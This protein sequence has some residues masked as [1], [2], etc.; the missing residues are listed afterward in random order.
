MTYVIRLGYKRP[1]AAYRFGTQSLGLYEVLS[2]GN[3]RSFGK[4]RNRGTFK[5]CPAPCFTH[6]IHHSWEY[7]SSLVL[8]FWTLD[9]GLSPRERTFVGKARDV[10][11]IDARW[12]PPANIASK[13]G[14][15]SV[16]R[17]HEEPFA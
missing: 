7:G 12:S 8:T 16:S 14:W 15:C 5:G 6:I 4:E 2:G 3:W 9:P 11:E 17:Q 10:F 13:H 1:K